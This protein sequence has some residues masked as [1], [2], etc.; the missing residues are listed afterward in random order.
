MGPLSTN[1]I[2]LQLE[3]AVRF[4]VSSPYFINFDKRSSVQLTEIFCAFDKLQRRVPDEASDSSSL[5]GRY[6]DHY[7]RKLWSREECAVI[8]SIRYIIECA[9]DPS[10]AEDSR[11]WE[12]RS[13]RPDNS[14]LDR[15]TTDEEQ[16]WHDLPRVLKLGAEEVRDHII[17]TIIVIPS[18]KLCNSLLQLIQ[19]SRAPSCNWHKPG[20][21]TRKRPVRIANNSLKLSPRDIPESLPF[22]P[23]YESHQED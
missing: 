15:V 9:R 8:S 21:S 7:A 17:P 12:S 4:V 1:E 3:R 6:S 19:A 18:S 5:P 23:V 11:T 2:S 16:N 14:R 20:R 22:R 13:G 10:E